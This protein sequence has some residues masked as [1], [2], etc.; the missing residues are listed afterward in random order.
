MMTQ[1]LTQMVEIASVETHMACI[2]T[3]VGYVQWKATYHDTAQKW[4]IEVYGNQTHIHCIP[5]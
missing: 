2:C 3:V 4:F 1:L 5:T